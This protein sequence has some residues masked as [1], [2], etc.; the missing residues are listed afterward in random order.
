MSMIK[1]Y[2]DSESIMLSGSWIC[3]HNQKVAGYGF[4]FGAYVLQYR[5]ERHWPLSVLYSLIQPGQ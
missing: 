2:F 5:R 3:N 1:S 4:Y